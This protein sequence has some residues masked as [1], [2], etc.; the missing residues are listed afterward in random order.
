VTIGWIIP[1]KILEGDRASRRTEVTTIRSRVRPSTVRATL[2]VIVKTDHH[3]GFT[4]WG[5]NTIIS[6]AAK[7]RNGFSSKSSHSSLF[8]RRSRTLR[9]LE[10]GTNIHEQGG[11]A[12]WRATFDTISQSL[13]RLV[14]EAA[15]MIGLKMGRTLDTIDYLSQGISFG[16]RLVGNDGRYIGMS[17]DI[18]QKTQYVISG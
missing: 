15:D 5:R 16:Y 1:T 7:I 4:G 18:F 12:D 11:S 6:R 2:E 10:K 14:E 9:G 13:E 17:T 8:W 3:G